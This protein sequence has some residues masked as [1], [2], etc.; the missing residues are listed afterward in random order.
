MADHMLLILPLLL[1]HALCCHS[2]MWQCPVS[3]SSLLFAWISE[4]LRPSNLLATSSLWVMD[5]MTLSDG[6]IM[7]QTP[8]AFSV[9][10]SIPSSP[11]KHRKQASRST[12]EPLPLPDLRGETRLNRRHTPPTPTAVAR[13]KIQPVL[14][15]T[16][17][18]VRTP[19]RL[20]RDILDNI[21]SQHI[22]DLLLL[23]AALNHKSF[24]P[25][26]GT[27]CAE[28]REQKLR[29]VLV[30]AVHALADLGDVGEDGFLVALAETLGRWD[31]VGARATG[32]DV[33]VVLIELVVEAREEELVGDGRGGGVRPDARAGFGVAGLGGGG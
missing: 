12:Q 27:R 5:A 31:F 17:L 9:D 32:E 10:S 7:L 26:D 28:L 23:E 19:A 2:F 3:M 6:M 24:T 4:Q 29:D 15:F 16:Q 18:R 8:S 20:A 22:L 1:S 30:V 11:P 33:W 14:A 25:V 21:P 13:D